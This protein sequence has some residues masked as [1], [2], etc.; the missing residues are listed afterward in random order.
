MLPYCLHQPHAAV[1]WIRKVAGEG[2]KLG[3]INWI[4]FQEIEQ[5]KSR[6]QGSLQG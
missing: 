2:G 3:E 1:A 6:V 4:S 5:R